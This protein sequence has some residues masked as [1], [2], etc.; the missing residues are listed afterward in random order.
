MIATWFE[1]YARLVFS[2]EGAIQQRD[3]TWFVDSYYGPPQIRAVTQQ[4]QVHSFAELAG[5][6][7]AFGEAL[8]E[9]ALPPRRAVFLEKQVRALQAICRLYAGEQMAFEQV[10]AEAL[11]LQPAWKPDAEFADWLRRLDLV[12]PGSGDVRTRFQAWLVR[13]TLPPERGGGLTVL[14]RQLL[15]EAR[16]R[17][18]AFV[19]LPPGEELDLQFVS[20]KLYSAANW[21]QGGYR[22]RLEYNLS[23]PINLPVLIYQMCH[24]A[25]PGHHTE[26]A[27]KDQRLFREQGCLEQSL[28]FVGPSLVI[29]EGI[30]LL[31]TEMIFTPAELADWLQ[32]RLLPAAGLDAGVDDLAAVL[33]VSSSFYM[34]ELSSNLAVL[35]AQGRTPAELRDYALACTPFTQ[36]QIERTIDTLRTPLGWLYAFSYYQGKRLMQPLLQR[37]DRLAVFRRLLSEQLLPGDLLEL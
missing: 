6:A 9:Q 21:Y 11:D 27:L 23:R 8:A 22:S 19:E 31:A 26:A 25:Y 36:D 5:Q 37:P 34:D 33:E 7:A 30:A 12:L 10:V 2:I 13:T 3:G 24:E 4:A 20:E 29:A 35:Q 28:T 32:E 18:Q 1:D 14:I 17:T 16:R 15:A